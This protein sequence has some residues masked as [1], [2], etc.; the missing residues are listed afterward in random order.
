MP[1]VKSPPAGSQGIVPYLLYKDAGAAIDFLVAAFGF[2]ERVRFPNQWGGVAHGELGLGPDIV[3][4]A[5][6]AHPGGP[7]TVVVYVDD[8]DAHH[9]HA[10]AAGAQTEGPPED[11]AWGDRVYAALDPEGHRWQFHTHV[12]DVAIHGM[13]G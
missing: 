13:D 2:D 4:V 8:V 5:D 6:A 7:S 10:V 3:M 9:A 1:A 12:R 11:Q